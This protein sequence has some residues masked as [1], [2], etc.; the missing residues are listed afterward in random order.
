MCL[1][2]TKRGATYWFRRSIPKELRSILGTSEF[3]WS[4]KTKDKEEA[5]ELRSKEAVRTDKLIADAKATLEHRPHSTT[6]PAVPMREPSA[7]EVE[8]ARADTS[9]IISSDDRRTNAEDEVEAL[10][11]ALSGSTAEMPYELRRFKYL[12]ES[13]EFERQVLEDRLRV[14]QVALREQSSGA[15]ASPVA[16][17][18]RLSVTTGGSPAAAP[19][20]DP[21]AIMLDTTIV[22][23]WSK[24]RRV[25]PKG[26]AAHR[27]AARDFYARVGTKPIRQIVRRDI[28]SYKDALVAELTPATT[29]MRLS[30]LQ[31]LL[32]WAEN[33]DHRDGNPAK[34]VRVQDTDAASRER[35]PFDLSALNAIFSS[36]V[37]AEGARPVQGRGEAAYWI[38]VL[39]IFTGARLE[40]IGQLRPIDVRQ[41][42]FVDPDGAE[43]TA[44]FIE[45]TKAAGKLK[46]TASERL[47]PVHAELE[48]L[49]FIRFAIAAHEEGRERLF[50]LL[51][52]GPHGNLTH[53]WGQWFG[54][55]LR[56]VCGVTDRRMTF[57]SFRHAFTDYARRPDIPEGIQRRLVGHGAADVHDDYGG[58]YFQHWLVESMKLYRVPGLRLPTDGG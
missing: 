37:F 6:S 32:Q 27:A 58:G 12:L 7:F 26:I 28:L 15:G 42:T 47:I 56:G 33:N 23:L 43:R 57:H 2:L 48:R 8:Q 54:A 25:D 5:K 13:V 1:Y 53:K 20:H 52:P 10:R 39:A 24:E 22:D 46:N 45:V 29:N 38:P 9:E 3:T 36:P 41:E 50:P 40:E 34:G 19:A 21:G 11:L 51:T 31:T 49:G 30:R 14:A 44:W 55:Y 16:D 35:K 18:E 4:L 17:H